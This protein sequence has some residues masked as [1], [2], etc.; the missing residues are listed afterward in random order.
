M[1][2][3][4]VPI[5]PAALSWA[6][7]ESGYSR[8]KLAAH[9]G[10]SLETV[11]AWI[12]GRAQPTITKFRRIAAFLKRT[13]STLLLPEP[14]R[15]VYRTVK[16]RRP[17]GEERSELNPTERRFLREAARVQRILSWVLEELGEESLRLPLANIMRDDAQELALR[18]RSLLALTDDTQVGWRSSSQALDAWRSKLE[19]QGV[20]IFLLPLGESACRGFSLWDK[21]APAIAINTAWNTE[22]RIF[23]LLHEYGH[24]LTRTDSACIEDGL[25]QAPVRKDDGVER[26]CERF[27]AAVLMPKS[28]FEHALRAEFR[29]AVPRLPEARFLARRF[30]VSLRAAVIRLIELNLAGRD[31]YREVPP[32]SDKKAPGGGG[33][34]RNRLQ[35]REDQFGRRATRLFVRAVEN[36]V[37]TRTD[38]L[39]VL[40][41]ADSDLETLQR[42]ATS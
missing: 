11:E 1:R 29:A 35:V 32:Q 2:G 34:G 15:R 33:R 14:P 24:L 22:A 4:C 9:L 39:G 41:I 18:A 7:E 6:I 42:S 21:K 19:E 28:A 23:S 16:F 8:E 5:T 20:L 27:S 30:K 10:V 12:S 36:D 31:L 26:W 13:P 38:V 37:L 17:T 25:A 40:D 3:V